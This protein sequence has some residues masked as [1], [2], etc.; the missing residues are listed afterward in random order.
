MRQLLL[1]SVLLLFSWS[2]YSQN[3]DQLTESDTITVVPTKYSPRLAMAM[4]A[5]LPGSGQIYNKKYWKVPIIYI[6]GGALVYSTLY[7]TKYYIEFRDAF[8]STEGGYGVGDFAL[9]SSDQ[10]KSIKDQYRRYRDMSIIGLGLLYVLNIVD[11]AVDGYLFDYDISD[12]LSLRIEP[13]VIQNQY[14]ADQQIG[15]K[16]T[17]HF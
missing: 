6:G 4:S 14:R 7:N 5:V 11:V 1:I 10:L 16:C 8:N 12:D 2:S 3:E 13:N 15:L 17:I 9:Y